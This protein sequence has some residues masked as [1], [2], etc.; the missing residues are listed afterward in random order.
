MLLRLLPLLFLPLGT[1]Q[2][3]RTTQDVFMMQYFQRRLQELEVRDS[4]TSEEPLRSMR[5]LSRRL[6]S[7]RV[8]SDI[9]RVQTCC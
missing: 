7:L 6:C 9:Q 3:Q 8:Y 1:G 5:L 2:A 4:D